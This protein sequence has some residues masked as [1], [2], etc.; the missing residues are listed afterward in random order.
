MNGILNKHRR[1]GKTRRGFRYE[2]Q[3]SFSARP[4][5]SAVQ[6]LPVMDID[7]DNQLTGQVIGHAIAVHRE[8][9]PGLDEI[10]YEEALSAKLTRAGVRNIRQFA[11]PLVYN[12]LPIDC[13]YRLDLLVEGRLPLELKAVERMLPIFEAQLLTYQRVGNFPLGLLVNFDVAVLKDGIQRMASTPLVVSPPGTGPALDRERFDALSGDIL[14]AAIEVHRHLGAGLLRSA[15]EACL[16][17]ELA[18]RGIAFERQRRISIASDGVV[19]QTLAE[20]SLLVAGSVPVYCLSVLELTPLHIARLLGRL[21]QGAWPYGFLLNF[22][23]PALVQ[24]VRRVT[25]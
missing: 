3:M 5:V 14:D 22:N 8:L 21:R 4:P 24:G 12:G 17:H 1:D 11:L 10:A 18:Q 20:V 6:F 7:S 13:G 25:R 15:Y 16:C 9:G 2:N 19:L 23:A